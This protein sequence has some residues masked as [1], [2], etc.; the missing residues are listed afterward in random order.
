[1]IQ[2]VFRIGSFSI[3]P[4]GLM[5]VAALGAAYWQLAR[6]LKYQQL[7]DEEDA[8]AIIFAC[9]FFG[10]LGGKVYY[11]LLMGDWSYLVDR[12]GI[13]WYGCFFGGLIAFLVTVKRRGLPMGLTFDAAAPGLALGYAVGRV[14]CFLV[15]DDYGVPTDLPWG[16]KFEVGL[17]PTS[18]GVLRRE[19][20]IELP[21][22]IS[23]GAFVAVHP[24][25]LYETLAALGIFGILLWLR[26]R[27]ESADKPAANKAA[28]K[29]V[30]PSTT[31]STVAPGSLMMASIALLSVERFLVEFIRA[32]DDRFLGGFTLAQGIS[33]V[34]LIGLAA[35]YWRRRPRGAEG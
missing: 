4:F 31:S 12:A 24:T 22:E 34:V 18:A 23:D 19:Y 35:L 21:P 32:K 33:V 1:M 14:G 6:G 30:A 25:Q 26:R 29:S 7:G 17:P 11:A 9:G 13:V 10:I 15:G 20:G 2:E 8:S 3:S 5:L 28:S 16:V 27:W